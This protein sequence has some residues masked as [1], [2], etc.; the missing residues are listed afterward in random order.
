MSDQFDD[1]KKLAEMRD[2]GEI[3]ESEYEVVKAELLTEIAGS[4][5]S[6]STESLPAGWYND[7]EGRH[8]HQAYWD[9]EKWTGAT[10]PGTSPSTGQQE[11]I[12]TTNKKRSKTIW[13]V[14]GVLFVLGGIGIV[15]AYF[16]PGSDCRIYRGELAEIYNYTGETT[17][18]VNAVVAG[19]NDGLISQL[20]FF[21]STFGA[22]VRMKTSV[23]AYADLEPPPPELQA[24]HRLLGTGIA[25]IEDGLANLSISSTTDDDV[26]AEQGLGEYNSGVAI[27]NQFRN[28][29][30]EACG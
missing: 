30:D 8:H 6:G 27:L 9:G 18:A 21:E 5:P 24:A 22:S 11:F 1:L 2:A 7:P 4:G 3:T 25:T 20:Q 19:W 23:D 17:D 14:L 15:S 13:L 29:A 26:L 10:Q 12:T 16:G 28:K